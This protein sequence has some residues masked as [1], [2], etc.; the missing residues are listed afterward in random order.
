MN[1]NLTDTLN[2]P[3]LAHIDPDLLKQVATTL[4]SLLACATALQQHMGQL[5]VDVARLESTLQQ[6]ALPAE[7]SPEAAPEVEPAGDQDT[8]VC[9]LGARLGDTD[10]Y[11]S[12]DGEEDPDLLC[13][14]LAHAGTSDPVRSWHDHLEPYVAA[15]NGTT[16]ESHTNGF[17][18]GP[19]AVDMGVHP[20]QDFVV[21]LIEDHA[22]DQREFELLIS[23][24]RQAL[25]NAQVPG[26]TQKE[27]P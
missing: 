21:V 20:D 12:W 6:S 16:T 5:A 22:G 14:T 2:H 18:Y 11:L 25:I 8:D 27:T 24:L 1:S 13:L 7:V 10:V 15:V 23:D 19:W 17:S 26:I 4:N 9:E 3:T